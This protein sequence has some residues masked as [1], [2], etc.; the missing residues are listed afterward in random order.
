M[1]VLALPRFRLA[2]LGAIPHFPASRAGFGIDVHV[3]KIQGYRLLALGFG[4][5][6][7][8]TPCAGVLQPFG[9]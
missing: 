9:V 8:E 3:W 1:L 6:F 4:R 7:V 5:A 2:G